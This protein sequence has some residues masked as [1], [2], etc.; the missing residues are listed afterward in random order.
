MSD[1]KDEKLVEQVKKLY[2]ELLNEKDFE[3]LEA[4]LQK[5]NIFSILGI[6]RMEIRHS[7]FLAWLLDPNGSHGL[8]NRFLIKI[9]RDLAIENNDLDIFEISNL[10]FNNVEIN[11]EMSSYDSENKKNGSIDL[12][13]D[14][15][16]DKLVICI[17]NKID[18]TDS[19]EQLEKYKKYIDTTKNFKEYKN[20]IFV[21]L[22][23]FGDKPKRHK[24]MEWHT[25]SY[26]RNIVKHLENIQEATINSSVKTYISDYLSTL[27]SEIMGTKDSATDLASKIYEKHSKIFDFVNENISKE[28]ITAIWDNINKWLKDFAEKLIQE[29]NKIDDANHYKLGFTQT[30]ISIKRKGK[31]IYALYPNKDPKC[32]LE[33][34]FNKD[35][36]K[37]KIVELLEKEKTDKSKWNDGVYFII[38]SFDEVLKENPDIFQKIHKIR[39]GI[40][41]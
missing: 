24:G 1:D 13:I 33:I 17:E 28:T 14:F 35:E 36:D 15:W 30:Y 27:K 25:Y 10:N 9:M 21:Y 40:T 16:S 19:E 22:T 2:K 26:E 41:D 11:R 18:A 4:E 20:R 31:I 5:P 7:S 6:G 3:K 38:N 29:I 12:L 39:F 37:Q 32:S 8:G 34:S 23:P